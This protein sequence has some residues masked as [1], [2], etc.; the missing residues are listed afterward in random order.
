[1]QI[2]AGKRQNQRSYNKAELKFA[3]TTATVILIGIYFSN[4]EQNCL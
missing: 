3:N 4:A 1:M 2:Y